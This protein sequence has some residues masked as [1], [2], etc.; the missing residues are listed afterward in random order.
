MVPAGFREGGR[1]WKGLDVMRA[2]RTSAGD[3]AALQPRWCAQEQL[4]PVADRTGPGDGIACPV[5]SAGEFLF[6]FGDV[7]DDRV[8][9]L[10]DEL[11]EKRDVRPPHRPLRLQL[12]ALGLLFALAATAVLRHH[13]LAACAIWPSVA[14]VYVVAA[15]VPW[16][17]RP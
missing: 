10:L 14:S 11:L 3:A 13:L 1:E 2:D 4:P 9:E 16:T 7:I 17:E 5:Q 6:R 8:A 12:A 15:L